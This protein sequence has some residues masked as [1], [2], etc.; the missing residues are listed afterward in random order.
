MLGLCNLVL[1][2]PDELFVNVGVKSQFYF[3]IQVMDA[4]EC[5]VYNTN[6]NHSGQKCT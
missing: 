6:N 2:L 1:Y 5:L 4:I 3:E